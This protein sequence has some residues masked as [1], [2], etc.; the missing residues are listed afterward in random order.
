MAKSAWKGLPVFPEP[1][2]F[3]TTYRIAEDLE[4]QGKLLIKV[5]F[6]S[7]AVWVFPRWT[8]TC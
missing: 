6:S 8:S 5:T 7:K 2:V 4:K 1:E 3:V